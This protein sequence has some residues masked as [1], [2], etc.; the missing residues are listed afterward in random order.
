MKSTYS[1][2]IGLVWYKFGMT[3]SYEYNVSI[4]REMAF[5]I[6]LFQPEF[7]HSNFRVLDEL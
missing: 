7:F 3:L 2:Y 1:S 6:S 5:H 4:G